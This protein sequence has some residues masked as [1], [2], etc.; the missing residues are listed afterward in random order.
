MLPKVLTIL[1][2]IVRVSLIIILM[3]QIK[4]FLNL[5]IIVKFLDT[6]IKLF[7]QFDILSHGRI[8]LTCSHKFF[9]LKIIIDANLKRESSCFRI[10]RAKREK[11]G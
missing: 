9:R 10:K 8:L 4:L 5:S 7:L 1:Q 11:L 2:F 3:V 6:L